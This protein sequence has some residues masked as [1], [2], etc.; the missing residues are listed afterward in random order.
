MNRFLCTVLLVGLPMAVSAA[1]P[2][3]VALTIQETGRAQISELHDI[4]PPGPDGLARIAP[5]PET[6]LPSSVHAVPAERGASLDILSQRFDFDLRDTESLFRAYRGRPITV[7]KGAE[8]HSG[9]LVS[10][11]DFSSSAPALTLAA[12]DQPILLVPD[13]DRLDSITFPARAD[14]AR[15]PTLLWQT[16]AGQPL[17]PS[18]RLHYAADGLDWSAAH[19]AV[20]AEDGRSMTLSSRVRVR[21]RTRRD[22]ANAR[23]RLALAD[24]GRYSPLV[25]ETDDLRAGRRPV[26]RVAAD[27]S[28]WV[29]ERAAATASTIATYDLLQPLSLPAGGEVGAELAFAESLPVETRHVYDGVRFDRYQR[30][31]RTDPNLGTEFSPAVETRIA[32]R[33]PAAQPLPPGPFRLLRGTADRAMQWIGSD[34]LPP[35]DPDGETSLN[36]GPAAGLSG[37]R[38]R[39]AFSEIVPLKTAEESF[40]ITIDNQTGA[41]QDV[42]VV[43]HLYRGDTYEIAAASAEHEPGPVPRSIQFQTPVPA[44]ASKT[45]TYTVRYTW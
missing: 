8:T 21:N 22:F 11:P 15:T 36:L 13:L 28:G 33:N 3:S 6:L 24:K 40:E 37:R 23:I 42:T 20:L 43:E 2:R 27:G 44:G 34:W 17:P 39:T 1:N 45:I 32:F 19:E 26:L 31:R 29:P 16:A 9:R 38:I 30:N 25:P 10:V 4:P 18:V 12:Q 35:L 14:L 41:D 7:R 5:V